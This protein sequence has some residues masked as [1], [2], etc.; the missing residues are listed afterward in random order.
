MYFTIN[1][2]VYMQLTPAYLE[3]SGRLVNKDVRAKGVWEVDP[4][5]AVIALADGMRGNVKVIKKGERYRVSRFSEDG[6][7]SGC[8]HLHPTSIFWWHTSLFQVA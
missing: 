2:K 7:Y 5:L 1:T 8:V 3:Q 6:V 4:P